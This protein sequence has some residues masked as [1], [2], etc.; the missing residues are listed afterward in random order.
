MSYQYLHPK[1]AIRRRARRKCY[2]VTL[3]VSLSIIGISALYQVDMLI[4]GTMLPSAPSI[5]KVS[6]IGQYQ[7][8]IT[9][10]GSD[11]VADLTI[12]KDLQYTATIVTST[13]PA[14]VRACYQVH[15]FIFGNLPQN[16]LTPNTDK[17]FV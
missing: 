4:R 1:Y 17:M 12:L 11:F 2:V 15:Y 13:P 9:L 7:Y 5:A 6:E 3:A 10:F 16:N 14:F 8:N